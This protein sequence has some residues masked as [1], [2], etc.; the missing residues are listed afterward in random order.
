[1]YEQGVAAAER[2]LGPAAFADNVFYFWGLVETRPYMR[3]RYG[4][5]RAE[6]HLG[7]HS[8]AIAHA[9]ELLRLNPGDNQGIRYVLLNWL[10]AEPDRRDDV[11]KLLLRYDDASAEWA[12][13]RALHL[14]KMA[15]SSK[16]AST[17]LRDAVECNRHVPAYL[18]RTKQIPTEIPT[19]YGFGDDSE[20]I[21][22]ADAAMSLWDSV[23]GAIEWL[24]KT[25]GE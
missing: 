23:P 20:A 5:A 12:Y 4:L 7:N 19:S 13:G 15:G 8:A 25:A 3:A 2:V 9:E 16:R 6:Y 1:M 18:L 14:F 24:R 17:A 22:Y 11:A 21:L 10:L